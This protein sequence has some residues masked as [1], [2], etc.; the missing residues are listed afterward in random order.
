MKR[1]WQFAVKSFMTVFG[2]SLG[3]VFAFFAV[4]ALV[5]SASRMGGTGF[6]NLPNAEGRVEALGKQSPILAVVEMK[7]SIAQ[8]KQT[9]KTIQALLASFD[10]FPLKERVKG[11]LI[12]MDCPGGEVFEIARIYSILRSWKSQTQC[13]IFVFVNGLCASGGYYVSCAADKIYASPASLIGSIGVRSG[14]YFNVKEGLE[15]YGV[16]SALLTSGTDKAPLN[17]Y[18]PWTPEERSVRQEIVDYLYNQFVDIVITN[19][20][21][22][23]EQLVDKLGAKLYDPLR[24]LEEGLIDVAGATREQ[25]LQEL[26]RTCKIEEEYRVIGLGEAGWLKRI[27]TAC[28]QSP[29]ITGRLYH[30]LLP[31]ESSTYFYQ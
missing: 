26:A 9:A 5:L 23:R 3:V 30:Q 11:I 20:P 29:L 2:L 22:T 4:S 17:P 28:S 12:D 19:R 10:S 14:P 6:S 18:T 24:A 7:D 25:V 16:Q 15:R 27:M 31:D 8:S 1:F 21:I 13:P